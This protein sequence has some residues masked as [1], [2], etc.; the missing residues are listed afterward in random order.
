VKSN[1]DPY[2][3]YIGYSNSTFGPPKEFP[4]NNLDSIF[5]IELYDAVSRD[6][7]RLPRDGK[8][9]VVVECQFIAS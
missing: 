1:L 8:D 6:H 3:Q 2:E 4:L 7:V 5:W 9:T